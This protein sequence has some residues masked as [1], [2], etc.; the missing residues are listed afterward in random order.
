VSDEQA[1]VSSSS[2]VTPGGRCPLVRRRVSF[3]EP[4]GQLSWSFV[5][6]QRVENW[7]GIASLVQ[8]SPFILGNAAAPFEA[9][10][11]PVG[12][13]FRDHEVFPAPDASAATSAAENGDRSPLAELRLLQSITT[14]R[15]PQSGFRLQRCGASH[16]VWSPS[17]LEE[18]EVYQTPGLPHPVRSTSRVSHPLDGLLPRNPAGPVSCR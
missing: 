14:G 8:R 18:G 12:P 11:G 9:A 15:R 4:S 10:P 13:S 17:A 6:P 16:E 7:S 5:L 3:E 1:S 2:E